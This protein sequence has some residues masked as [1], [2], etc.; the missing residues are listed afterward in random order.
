[1]TDRD[2]DADRLQD[3]LSKRF[4]SDERE[5]TK[6]AKQDNQN[7]EAKQNK[8]TKQ[9]KKTGEK[10]STKEAGGE[11]AEQSQPE[12]VDYRDEW[13]TRLVY[14][15]DDLSD[16]LEYQY[17]RLD[18]ETDWEVKKE[19]HFYPVVV[20]HGIEHIA[21]MDPEEFTAAVESLGVGPT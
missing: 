15:P 10:E 14:L 2:G 20:A 21:E 6:Q 19:Q 8:D 3:R 18:L 9:A 5:S 4:D 11:T 12:T 17:K 1:M 16:L 7:K 13:N